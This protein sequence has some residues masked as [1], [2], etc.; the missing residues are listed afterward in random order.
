LERRTGDTISIEGN[1]QYKSFN[2]QNAVQRFWHQS[3]ARII[4]AALPTCLGEQV[5][6]IG[7]GSGVITNF[8]ASLGANA[9]GI[10]GSPEAIDFAT[11]TFINPNTKF[12]R[13]F[14]DEEFSLPFLVDKIYCLEV[15]EHIYYD[16][17]KNMLLSFNKLLKP[18]GFVFLT[19]PNYFGVWPII[20]WI[21]DLFQVTPKLV[22]E[23]HVEFYNT[24]KL[25]TLCQEAGFSV[26][27]TY[28]VNFLAPWIA[29]I[30]WDLAIE[31]ERFELALRCPIG[32]SLVF[33]L[34]KQL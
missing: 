8:L 21:F 13:G 11:K 30:S 6:D 9:I 32:S 15:I 7:C 29:P 34:R 17:G 25:K 22:G 1:Y 28:I 16:Q 3:K 2:S 20:E 27:Q 5:L 23:Q 14:V 4:Q 31:M 33:I 19:T 10:D 12:I 26:V 18:N 24:N